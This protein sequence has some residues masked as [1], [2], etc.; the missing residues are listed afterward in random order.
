MSNNVTQTNI[1][2]V[3]REKFLDII[4]LVIGIVVAFTVL[5]GDTQVNA[6]EIKRLEEKVNTMEEAIQVVTNN[7]TVT[8]TSIKFIQDDIGEIKEMFRE[9]I[10]SK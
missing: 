5:R 4:L 7:S 8:T 9:H 3:L 2:G 10:S 6:A 1:M